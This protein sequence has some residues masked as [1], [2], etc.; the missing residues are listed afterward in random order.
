MAPEIAKQATFDEKS[1]IYSLSLVIYALIMRRYPYED[2]DS[3][4]K[5]DFITKV[6]FF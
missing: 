2:L 5:K 4:N 1:D 6:N 3:L